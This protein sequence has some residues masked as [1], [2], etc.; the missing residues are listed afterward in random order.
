MVIVMETAGEGVVPWYIRKLYYG[1][2][3]YFEG[4]KLLVMEVGK[5]ALATVVMQ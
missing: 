4:I 5:M 1:C 2:G 3:G